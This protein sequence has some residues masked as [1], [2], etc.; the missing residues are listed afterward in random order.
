MIHLVGGKRFKPASKHGLPFVTWTRSESF[1]LTA[2]KNLPPRND[3]VK[4]KDSDML[5]MRLAFTQKL[6]RL[7]EDTLGKR[8]AMKT[9]KDEAKE[10]ELWMEAQA[11]KPKRKKCE[12]P[13]MPCPACSS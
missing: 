9:P 2:F 1:A 11:N 6:Q 10:H 13:R 3:F 4:G 8:S 7:H 12:G 5:R